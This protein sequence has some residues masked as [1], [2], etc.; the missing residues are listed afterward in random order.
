M[1]ET[2]VKCVVIEVP[3]ELSVPPDEL[4]ERLRI[5]LALGST[6]RT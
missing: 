6:R 4:E 5:E 2:S 1:I 3:E